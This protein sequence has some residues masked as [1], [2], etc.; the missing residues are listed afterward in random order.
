MGVTQIECMDSPGLQEEV[1][2]N[3]E[4]L[5]PRSAH[6]EKVAY[7]FI[8]LYLAVKVSQPNQC[9]WVPLLTFIA[10]LESLADHY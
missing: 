8:M 2:H 9:L 7:L 5:A 6:C 4:P 1:I 10:S 3:R